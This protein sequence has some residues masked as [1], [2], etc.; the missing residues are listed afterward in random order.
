MADGMFGNIFDVRRQQNLDLEKSAM[1]YASLPRG[2]AQV[3]AAGI[4]GGLG[5]RAITGALGMQT[6]E[7]MRVVKSQQIKQNALASGAD[8]NDPQTYIDLAAELEANGLTSDAK[9]ALEIADALQT[10]KKERLGEIKL[11][12]KA[13]AIQNYA[14][15][16]YNQQI[17]EATLN[18]IVSFSRD[19]DTF[20]PEFG[21]YVNPWQGYVDQYFQDQGIQ[22]I[23][24]TQITPPNVQFSGQTSLTV[25]KKVKTIFETARKDQDDLLKE[26]GDI[27]RLIGDSK[28]AVSLMNGI[29]QGNKSSV[30][31]LQD[32]L[33]RITA[34]ERISLPE[35]ASN[36]SIGGLGARISDSVSMFLTGE[37]TPGTIDDI[38]EMM[39]TLNQLYT[40]RYN[41]KSSKYMN[42]YKKDI[43]N[44]LVTYDDL[45]NYFDIKQ[46]IVKESELERVRKAIQRKKNQ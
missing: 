19:K 31:R 34:D 9:M 38:E 17:D 4:A 10:K 18:E 40:S 8:R 41:E 21:E 1:D 46:P 23:D 43:D 37:L 36:S 24:K 42:R 14:Q 7:E 44:G 29:R 30:R 32:I 13:N 45:Q 25:P 5:G 39:I 28:T 2:R 11:R 3:A 22:K 35:I 6:P 20:S 12:D 33:S 26:T 15:R 16:T 27:S